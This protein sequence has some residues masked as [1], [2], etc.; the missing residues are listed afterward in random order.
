M[1]KNIFVIFTSLLSSQVLLSMNAEKTT[2]ILIRYYH[3][4]IDAHMLILATLNEQ[5]LLLAPPF[6]R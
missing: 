6:H 3:Y 4:Y 5:H 1:H 2:E